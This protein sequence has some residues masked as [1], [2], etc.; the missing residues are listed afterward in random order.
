[1]PKAIMI[2]QTITHGKNT[3]KYS[4]SGSQWWVYMWGWWPWGKSPMWRWVQIE[5]DRVPVEVR[6]TVE[7][8]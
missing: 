2:S 5:L 7:G 8:I 3:Y 4:A 6:D 1:M